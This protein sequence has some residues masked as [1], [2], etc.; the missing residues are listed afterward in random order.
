MTRG[1]VAAA[2]EARRGQQTGRWTDRRMALG[3]TVWLWAPRVWPQLEPEAPP[4]GMEGR[5]RCSWHPG[6][7]A[8]REA[9]ST[10]SCDP[11][12]SHFV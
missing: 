5:G 11:M 7:G 10:Q 9:R 6:L 8:L 2:G 4:T 12:T 3:C 1:V